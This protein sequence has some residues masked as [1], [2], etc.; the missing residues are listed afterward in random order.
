M[1]CFKVSITFTNTEGEDETKDAGLPKGRKKMNA[2]IKTYSR[3]V[4]QLLRDDKWAPIEAFNTK[5]GGEDD[6]DT[7]LTG[8]EEEDEE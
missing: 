5:K 2:K 1:S 7:M 3:W 4:I 6:K 8:G